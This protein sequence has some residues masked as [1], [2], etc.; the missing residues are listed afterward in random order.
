MP[1]HAAHKRAKRRKFKAKARLTFGSTSSGPSNLPTHK[2]AD[3]PELFA[4]L[5]MQQKCEE[6]VTSDEVESDSL[7]D[8]DVAADIARLLRRVLNKNGPSLEEDLVSALSPSQVQYVIYAYGTLASFMDHRPQFELDQEGRYIFVYY[9]GLDSEESDCSVSSHTQEKPNPG[10]HSSVSS[11]GGHQHADDGEP[12]R[13]RC[14][15]S[16]SSCYESAVEEQSEE[17]KHGLKDASCQVRLSPP[18]YSRGQQV[19]LET[20]DADAQTEESGVSR[21]MELQSTLQSL[22]ADVTRLKE[23]L[24]NVRQNQASVVQQLRLKTEKLLTRPQAATPKSVVKVRHHTATRDDKPVR[25]NRSDDE[26]HPPQ[27]RPPLRERNV[28]PR[29]RPENKL[30]TR[31]GAPKPPANDTGG[32]GVLEVGSVAACANG[33]RAAR[34]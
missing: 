4:G 26:V 28:P 25:K 10:R 24:E 8:W 22:D 32:Q 29:L 9:E 14:S 27:A 7:T 5:E 12:E 31:P 19:V 17:E 3:L 13:E 11:D 21:F 23:R 30:L 16:S 1:T 20:S 2:E 15:S 6:D 33:A 18:C 34:L